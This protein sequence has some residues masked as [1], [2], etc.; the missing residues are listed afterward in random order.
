MKVFE[1][2]AVKGS[3]M[4][5]LVFET[6]ILFNPP[7]QAAQYCFQFTWIFEIRMVF[8]D[9]PLEGASYFLDLLRQREA[10]IEVIFC[11]VIC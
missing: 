5:T 10:V 4:S 1:D 11:F 8:I 7:P 6:C 3:V 9:F 2:M